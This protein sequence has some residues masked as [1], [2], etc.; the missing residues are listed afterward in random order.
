MRRFFIFISGVLILLFYQCTS[1]KDSTRSYFE[2]AW[3][4]EWFLLDKDIQSMFS[5]SEITMCGQVIFDENETVEITAY[6]FD[7]CVF[8]SD[9]AKN[10][11]NYEFQDSLLNLINSEKEV[12]FAYQVK[13]KLQDK[14][15][16][17]LMDDIQ[18]TLRR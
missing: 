6:G 3:N 15:T 11:L 2:G 1:E 9:T 17:L 7:G 14:L 16:L 4:A 18:L 5:A 13:E 10:T 8:A 12:V